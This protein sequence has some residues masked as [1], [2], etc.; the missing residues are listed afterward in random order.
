M[1]GSTT[2]G[3]NKGGIVYPCPNRWNRSSQA[4]IRR[5]EPSRNIM[6]QSGWLAA[7]TT[8]ALYGPKSQIGL[9]WNRPPTNAIIANTIMKKPPPLAAKPGNIRTPTTFLLVRPGPGH[10]EIG[11]ASGR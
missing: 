1:P 6:Y 10:W 4:G 11:R 9:I 5:G 7:E 8:A 3:Q 2:V